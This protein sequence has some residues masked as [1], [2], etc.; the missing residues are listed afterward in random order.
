MG[1]DTEGH[2]NLKMFSDYFLDILSSRS[3]KEFNDWH[4][5]I[6]HSAAIAEKKWKIAKKPAF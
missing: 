1:G 4:K 6:Q 5:W 3:D 2:V